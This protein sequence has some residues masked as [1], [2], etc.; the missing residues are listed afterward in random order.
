ME[1][2]KVKIEMEIETNEESRVSAEILSDYVLRAIAGVVATN[3][4]IVTLY[5][6]SKQIGGND[7]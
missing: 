1:R 5:K 3:R 7:E 4:A 6:C 2:R